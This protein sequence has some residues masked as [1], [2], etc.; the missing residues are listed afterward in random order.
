[1]THA[2]KTASI[3]ALAVTLLAGASLAACN[4]AGTTQAPSS[5]LPLATAAAPPLADAPDANAL[6]AAPAA[7]VA[8]VTD[9]GQ[10]YSYADQAWAMSDAFAD[11]PPDYAFDDGGVTPWVWTA[12]NNDVRVA[13][14]VPGGERYYYYQPGADQPFYVQDPDYGYAYQVGALVAVYDHGGQ[15]VPV[16]GHAGVAGRY[17]ARGESLRR[18][19]TSAPHQPVAANNWNA[20]R[21]TIAAQRT[22]FSTQ[23]AAN[24]AWNAY[25]AQ[26]AAQENA[27]WAPEASKREA[28]AATTD[29][30]LG[31]QADAD[32]ER[33]QAQA[34]V[35]SPPPVATPAA[36]AHPQAPTGPRGYAP[37]V[38]APP[39]HPGAPRPGPEPAARPITPARPVP[40]PVREPPAGAARPAPGVHA[41]P[42]RAASPP[43]QHPAPG[44]PAKAPEAH[45]APGDKRPG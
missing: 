40:E 36:P 20:Q 22:T 44:H 19:A 43:Q 33:Q 38:G 13:E 37:P 32:R 9:P 11:S 12:S 7:P 39:Q 41:A 21:G 25:H 29:A 16:A 18:T 1:M 4:Q 23:A 3:K 34:G 10:S 17:L 6:P 15:S 26:N 14:A 5:A 35:H 27:Q 28:W 45:P 30:R 42:P 24:P 31:N 2:S 8:S